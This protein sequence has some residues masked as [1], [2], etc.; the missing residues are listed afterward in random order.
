MKL[1]D[2]AQMRA[3]DAM[4]VERGMSASLLMEA[5]G[6]SVA[7]QVRAFFP[8][9][10]RA[11]VVCGTGNN[12]GDGYVAARFLAT[13]P[14]PVMI[15]CGG[16]LERAS[17]PGEG[18]A[19]GYGSGRGGRRRA[20]P[21]V[22]PMTVRV[23]ELGASP[24]GPESRAARAALCA[25]GIEPRLHGG[26]TDAL[27]RLDADLAWCDV[28]V[29]GLFG[30]GLDRALDGAAAKIV[31]SINAS[32]AARVSIDVPSGVDAGRAV[33][34]GSHVRADLSV[35]LAGPKIASALFPARAAFGTSV[36]VGIGMPP[37]ILLS[38]SEL[39][40]MNARAAR[41]WLP[42]RAPDAHKYQVGT[43]LVVAGSRAYPGAAELACRAAYRAGSGLV[44]LA[45]EERF[46]GGWPEIV[47]QAVDWGAEHPLAWLEELDA[48]RA[49]TCV[50]GPGL[51]ERARPFLPALLSSLP[52]PVV[53]DAGALLPDE[54]LRDAVRA[55]GRCVLTPHLGEAAVLHGV[56]VDTV[57]QDPLAAAA[58]LARSF[59]AVV[60]LKGATTVI[61]SPDGRMAVSTRGHPGMAVGGSGDVLSG[62]LGAFAFQGPAF[63]RSC[64]GVFVHG[65]AGERAAARRG[66]GLVA[67]DILEAVP[68]VLERLR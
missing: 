7:D 51:D 8:T 64:A 15:A 50:I 31:E 58:G 38:V 6:R 46:P 13:P 24:R 14:E 12:G 9:A 52:G 30:S 35:Q 66:N 41:S 28:V 54:S 67:D 36:V 1:Y 26:G 56:S 39:E 10:H 18:G 65:L 49:S 27:A 44:T 47:L 42:Q 21:R 60:V 45:A 68:G 25:H 22:R 57:R 62:I 16:G 23:V 4:S 17:N 61:A 37:D 55:H 5:A 33:P 3:A 48:K 43:V 11:L 40:L 59:D 63:E 53:L 34:P 20:G 29:D 2:A 19:H 32:Q